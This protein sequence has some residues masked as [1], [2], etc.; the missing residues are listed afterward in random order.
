M[1]IRL[2][3]TESYGLNA[4]FRTAPSLISGSVKIQMKNEKYRSSILPIFLFAGVVGALL[5]Q[6]HTPEGNGRGAVKAVLETE[7]KQRGAHVFG[8]P[9]S[10]SFARFHEDNIEWVTLVPF[11]SQDDF[12]SPRVRHHNGDTLQIQ[13]HDSSWTSQIEIIR[14]EYDKVTFWDALD[15]IGIQ[16]YFPL[17]ENRNPTVE[18]LSAGWN[19]H[20]P[21]IRAVREK[22]GKKVL[23]TEMG[24]KSTEDSAIEPWEWIRRGQSNEERGYSLETQA[25]CYQAFFDTIWDADWFAGAHI[26]QLRVNSRRRRRQSSNLDFTP[27]DKPAEKVIAEGFERE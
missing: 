22:F 2:Y 14:E 8:R 26:W 11:G 9:D 17:V 23:F 3:R 7:D 21:T 15:Y 16:A 1:S 27:L 13:Y 20:L 12:D 5:F 10:T 6:C 24:Y 25:N 18:Q 19:R 4:Y